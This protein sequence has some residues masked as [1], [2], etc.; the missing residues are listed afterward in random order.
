MRKTFILISFLFITSSPLNSQ[1][2]ELNDPNL[3]GDIMSLLELNNV[4]F[5]GGTAYLFRSSD[6]GT[7]W[8][9]YFNLP[10]Y[11]WSLTKL[12]GNL[13]CG[14][15]YTTNP[16]PGVY[17]STD[18]G[19]NWNITSLSNKSVISMAAGD[20]FIVAVTNKV[21][22][23]TNDGQTWSSIKD[24]AFGYLAVS[25]N[26]IYLALSGLMV[27]SD[28]GN[29]WNLINNAAGISVAADDSVV[30]FGTQA[31][32]IYRST[33]NGQTWETKFNKAGAYVYS[34]YKYDHYVFAGTDSGFYY[35]NDNGDTFINKN[36]NL[37]LSRITAIMVYNNY[38]YA[39][40]GNY[41]AV[42]VSL[43]KRPL[44]E[45]TGINESVFDN[46]VSFSLS[47]NFPNPFN[48]STS[49]K[50]Q[51]S[52]NSKV[53]LK[54]YDVLGNE[55]TT[56]VNEQKPVGRY[57]VEF[58]ASNLP[59]GVYIYKIQAGSFVQSKKMMLVK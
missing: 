24:P 13:F 30:F 50:Y 9:A 44:T 34:L 28:F 32:I 37:S 4:L 48:P 51:V 33:N 23:S 47:Q 57:E 6:G 26:R 35:S 12:Y 16:I 5:A 31:G 45:F 21:E 7:T 42:P 58:D 22:L 19:L 38:I 15:A 59:S 17:K 18:V 46:P 2:I 27:T 43:W 1:W 14:I 3:G 39:A 8:N 49:I 29:S 52:S 54:V 25:N 40:N 36:D 11:A 20:S 41:S 55:V 53:T 56:L 10:A